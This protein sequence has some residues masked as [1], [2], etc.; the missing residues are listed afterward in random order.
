V[1]CPALHTRPCEACLGYGNQ[2]LIMP[3]DA[4]G[5]PASGRLLAATPIIRP[6]RSTGAHVRRDVAVRP[7]DCDGPSVLARQPETF[8]EQPLNSI[9]FHSR[10]S[11]PLTM[12]ACGVCTTGQT[13][14][15][16]TV[17]SSELPKKR[18]RDL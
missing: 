6:P 18:K 12:D 15:R 1:R 13:P 8:D 5:S 4:S 10:P 16:V 11:R 2:W 7:E 17:L 14:I 3:P 9:L